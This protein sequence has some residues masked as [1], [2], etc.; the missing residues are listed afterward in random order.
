MRHSDTDRS[1]INRETKGHLRPFWD[2]R[3]LASLADGRLRFSHLTGNLPATGAG[4]LFIRTLV[5]GEKGGN[6]NPARFV[7]L[8]SK[9]HI[10]SYFYTVWTDAHMGH[11]TTYEEGIRTFMGNKIKYT[12]QRTSSQSFHSTLYNHIRLSNTLLSN[13][14]SRMRI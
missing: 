11:N 5:M 10:L 3:L 13:Q 1:R 14:C 12:A 8:G 9:C 2:K 4:R 7:A 6:Y